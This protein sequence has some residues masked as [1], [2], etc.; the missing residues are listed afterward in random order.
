M[1]RSVALYLMMVGG[2]APGGSE[3]KA[4]CVLETTCAMAVAWSTWG[5]KNTLTMP[6][7]AMVCDSVCSMSLTALARLRSI[8][9]MTRSVISL[10]LRPL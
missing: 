4:A 6:R 1:G 7:P 2:V 10:A 3:R 8:G 9:V 5:W